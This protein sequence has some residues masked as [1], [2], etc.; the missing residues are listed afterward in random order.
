MDEEYKYY[1]RLRNRLSIIDENIKN[2]KGKIL[3]IETYTKKGSLLDKLIKLKDK[4]DIYNFKNFDARKAFYTVIISIAIFLIV[5]VLNNKFSNIPLI[6]P[7]AIC[8]LININ[9]L[10]FIFSNI[11][12]Y[13]PIKF[14]TDIVFKIKKRKNKNYTKS[15]Y[16]ILD[17]LLLEKKMVEADIRNITVNK[18]KQSD[19]VS[20]AKTCDKFNLEEFILE[21]EHDINSLS[22]K[23]RKKLFLKLNKILLENKENKSMLSNYNNLYIDYKTYCDLVKLKT[24]IMYI[25]NGNNMN[26]ELKLKKL[27]KH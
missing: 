13:L 11:L 7:T 25:N 26:K 22:K 21:I 9:L 10:S 15:F 18:F 17:N 3:E 19:I 6:V 24:T 5:F 1:Y 23:K 2:V 16:M 12:I 20:N 14:V 4:V 27:K 8:S